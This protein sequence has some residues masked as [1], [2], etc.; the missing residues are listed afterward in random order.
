[1][2]ANAIPGQQ[3]VEQMQTYTE[4]NSGGNT[5]QLNYRKSPRNRLAQ[6]LHIKLGISLA[7]AIAAVAAN[8]ASKEGGDE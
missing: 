5:L 7:H 1:M 2:R 8:N 4:T 6:R 3:K